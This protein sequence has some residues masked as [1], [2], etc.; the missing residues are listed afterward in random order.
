MLVAAV[1]FGDAASI[2]LGVEQ[3][4]GAVGEIGRSC[5]GLSCWGNGA[6]DFTALQGLGRVDG[7][8]AARA[9]TLRALSGRV[10]AV[11]LTTCVPP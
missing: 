6:L 5:H 2:A 10:G 11:M 8:G 7:R 9:D 1:K 3:R 4:H